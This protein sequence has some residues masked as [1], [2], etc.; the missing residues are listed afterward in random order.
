M[1]SPFLLPFIAPSLG[2]QPALFMSGLKGPSF[3]RMRES[4]LE[5]VC[6][7]WIPV[8]TG[9]TA[10]RLLRSRDIPS[11]TQKNSSIE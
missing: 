4:T 10:F 1:A 11:P 3:L 2:S 5:G 7:I 9:M 6:R 8:A